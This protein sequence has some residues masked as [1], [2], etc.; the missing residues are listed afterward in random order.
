VLRTPSAVRISML[1]TSQHNLQVF[2]LTV[3]YQ[4]LSMS[5]QS[6]L[7]HVH[8]IMTAMDRLP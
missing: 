1:Y 7:R 8:G 2:M 5:I 3:T 6:L 4:K